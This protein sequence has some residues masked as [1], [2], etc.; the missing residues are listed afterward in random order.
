M[1]IESSAFEEISAEDCGS[2]WWISY[3]EKMDSKGVKGQFCS[4][5]YSIDKKTV[6]RLFQLQTENQANRLDGEENQ[7]E[8][9][10]AAAWENPSDEQMKQDYEDAN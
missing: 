4:H 8:V 10:Q 3:I 1:I 5:S 7:Y 2:Y 9:D 6:A